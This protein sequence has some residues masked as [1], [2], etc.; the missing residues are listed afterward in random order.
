MTKSP[1]TLRLTFPCG[2][3]FVLAVLILLLLI[4]ALE[5]LARLPW[6]K[7]HV[8][9]AIGSAHEWL[10]VKFGDMDYLVS[11]K[12]QVDCV[13]LG[14]SIVQS[15]IDPLRFEKAYRAQTGEDITCYN[16]GS[17]GVKMVASVE[18]AEI[19]INRYHPRLLVY[20]I[21]ARELADGW[22]GAA[23]RPMNETP[24]IQYEL[25]AFNIEGWIVDHFTAYRHYLA[26]REWP[27]PDFKNPVGTMHTLKRR[28]F[29]PYT[30]YLETFTPQDYLQNYALSPKEWAALGQLIALGGQTQLLLLEMPLN[31]QTLAAFNGGPDSYQHLM[32]QVA[33]YAAAGDVPMWFTI[34]HHL[35]PP[36]G[37]VGDNHHMHGTGAKLFSAWLGEQVGQAV[38]QGRLSMR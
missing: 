23:Q 13:F 27:S 21:T 14:S 1:R 35:I 20:G 3:T 9:T 33:D 12:G 36:D 24:W 18:L 4:A 37:W 7:T 28:G 22:V 31:D 30:Y 29:V 25:G 16:F 34:Q 19:L 17:P 32:N 2:Q 10:D 26:L 38:N 8:P 5:G 11:Q 6:V 15:G